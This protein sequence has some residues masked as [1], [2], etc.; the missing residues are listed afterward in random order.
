MRQ[1]QSHIYINIWWHKDCQNV[2]WSTDARVICSLEWHLSMGFIF[3]CLDVQIVH[4]VCKCT[5]V[6]NVRRSCELEYIDGLLTIV[7]SFSLD[8]RVLPHTVLYFHEL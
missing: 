4:V 8:L 7:L 1:S 5:L 2:L 6:E 3:F